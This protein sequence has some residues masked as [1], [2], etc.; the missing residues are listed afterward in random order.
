MFCI[1]LKCFYLCLVNRKKGIPKN[2]IIKTY[3]TKV[4]K[5]QSTNLFTTMSKEAVENLT[6]EVKETLATGIDGD[7]KKS[8]GSLDLW[9]IYRQ[10]RVSALR[11]VIA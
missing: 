11:R 10:R 8:F 5:K 1:V 3:K 6:T 9:N 7:Q 4:M 2:S